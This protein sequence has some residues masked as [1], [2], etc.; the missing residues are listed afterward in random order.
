MNANQRATPAPTARIAM[1]DLEAP[2]DHAGITTLVQM[3]RRRI[4]EPADFGFRFLAGRE[5][6]NA[7]FT[8][9]ELDRRAR[10]VAAALSERG[11]QGE[12]ALLC[13][14]PGL[15]FL[16]GF[17]GSVYAGMVAVPAYPPRA[18]KPDARLAS[19]AASCRPA[20]VLTTA[21]LWADR[22]R[23]VAKMPEL[24][25]VDWLATDAVEDSRADQWRQVSAKPDDL[26]VLQYTSGSTGDPK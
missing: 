21:E 11:L 13:Y 2:S 3:L 20:V 18:H 24:A 8:F 14:P 10:A 4:D 5:E 17:F 9:A 19:M 12:R 23:L 1:I 15:E 22:A 16:V 25:Q 6:G 7:S 26:A